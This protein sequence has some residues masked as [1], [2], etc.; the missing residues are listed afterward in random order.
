MLHIPKPMC[1]N[2]GWNRVCQH[3]ETL[4]SKS[5]ALPPCQD[6]HVPALLRIVCIHPAAHLCTW[7]TWNDWCKEVT[8]IVEVFLPTRLSETNHSLYLRINDASPYSK[9]SEFLQRWL[10]CSG[11]TVLCCTTPANSTY[12]R[13]A[14]PTWRNGIPI[15]LHPQI[16]ELPPDICY[17]FNVPV[18]RHKF[19]LSLMPC[20]NPCTAFHV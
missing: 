2:K 14:H 17:A 18:Q 8:A 13:D 4:C 1:F 11:F 15:V 9:H 19:P 12:H 16:F 10:L 20:K 7:S 6:F 5:C 3:S